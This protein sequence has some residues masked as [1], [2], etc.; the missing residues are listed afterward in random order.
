MLL[1]LSFDVG[2][3]GVSSTVDMLPDRF[4]R[5]F[6]CYLSESAGCADWSLGIVC[7]RLVRVNRS[8]ALTDLTT[9]YESVVYAN[10]P[11]SVACRVGFSL[12][13]LPRVMMRGV[14][15][16]LLYKWNLSL[17]MKLLPL[18]LLRPFTISE[19]KPLP[20]SLKVNTFSGLR[21]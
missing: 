17:P 21:E 5:E 3:V 9:M 10:C 18:P 20:L 14:Y 8:I 16:A 15:A 4:W 11:F 12:V 2:L 13:H 19:S 1:V 7:R 6:R